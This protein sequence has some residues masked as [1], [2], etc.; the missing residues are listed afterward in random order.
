MMLSEI[1][2]EMEEAE[3]VFREYFIGWRAKVR[4]HCPTSIRWALYVHI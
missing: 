3:K 2:L 4:R 1:C